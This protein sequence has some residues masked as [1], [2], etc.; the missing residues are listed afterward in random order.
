MNCYF[1]CQRLSKFSKTTK[2]TVW[3]PFNLAHP[4]YNA[5]QL[6]EIS[7]YCTIRCWWRRVRDCTGVGKLLNTEMMEIM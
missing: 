3:A 2:E 6:A 4:V 7:F 1:T 5:F